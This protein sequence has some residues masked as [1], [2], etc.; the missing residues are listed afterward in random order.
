[1]KIY[2]GAE[3]SADPVNPMDA[4]TKQYVDNKIVTAAVNG[5]VFFTNIAPTTAGI[6]G[7]KQYVPNTV[8]ANKVILD[9]TTD[10]ANVRV[11]L[12]AEGGSAFYSPTIT[13]TTDPVLPG[14]PLTVPLTEDQYDKRMFAGFVDL[15]GV[16]GDTVITAS[17]TTNAVATCIVKRAAAGPSVSS[18][19]IGAYPGAQTETKSGDVITISGVVANS[20]S[21]IETIAGGASAAATSLTTLGAADSAGAGFRTFSGTFTVSGLTGNH[22]AVVRARNALGTFGDNRVSSNT[23]TLNQTAPTIGARTIAYPANQSALKGAETATISATVTNADAVVYSSS[24]DLSVE[25]ATTYAVAKTVARINGTYVFNVANYTITATKASNGAVSTATASVAI[26]NV[27]ATAT[28]AISGNPARLSSSAA[29][30][31]YVVTITP[32]QVLQ[33]APTL[34]ASSG[35]FTGAWTLN[36]NV[37]SRTLVIKDVDAK[38]PAT[39]SDLTLPGKAGLIG[40]TIVSGAAYTVGGF[41]KR[42]LTFAAFSQVAPLGTAVANIDKTVA[43]YAGSASNLTL[44]KDT[45]AAQSAYTITN[46]D[47]TYNPTGAYLFLNDAAYAGSNTSGTLQVEIEEVV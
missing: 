15:T 8:P 21:Y 40:S 39:F 18:A 13:I 11:S 19:T 30:Q 22:S 47:G 6:V 20:A 41:A 26:A 37:W 3:L 33:A 2:Q 12:L 38:G 45:T 27:F 16:T 36:G 7:A 31:N 29:G 32:N 35:T 4:T 46:A 24:A 43:N 5:G 1:M 25:D 23:I 44:M 9:G 42:M 14:T 10:T 28:V 17:S 34:V